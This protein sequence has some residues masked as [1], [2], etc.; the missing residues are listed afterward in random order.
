MA[1]PALLTRSRDASP[2]R[3]SLGGV[4]RTTSAAVAGSALLWLSGPAYALDLP[5]PAEQRAQ[6]LSLLK[7]VGARADRVLVSNVPGTVVNDEVVLVGLSEAGTPAR[8]LM[9]QRL[10]LTGIGDYNVRERG[11]ARASEALG[12]EPPPVTKFGAVV[13]QGFSPGSRELAARLTLDPVIEAARL[14]LQVTVSGRPLAPGGLVPAAGQV[15]LRLT[16]RTAQP[17]TLPTATDADA[18]AVARALDV[19]RAAAQAPAGPRLPAAGTGL[20]TGLPAAVPTTGDR[21]VTAPS[22]VSLRVTG[23]VRLVDGAGGTVTGPATTAVPGGAQV[24]GTLPPGASAD[25]VVQASGPGR[26][27]LDLTV[28]PALDPRALVP[29]DRAA[30]W[31]AWAATSPDRTARR[32]ALDLLVATASSGARATSLSPYLGADLPGSGT[33]RFTYAFA[34]LERAPVAAAPLQPRPVP[35]ALASV[36]LL[37]LGGG[38][39]RLWRRS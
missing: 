26:L 9:E 25:L 3:P 16:N 27:D 10:S 18:G 12:D 7:E 8:V 19:A 23:T 6:D 13:W 11:P 35:I 17:A 21:Q 39:V 36:A 5:S 33:T 15:V 32:A 30:S 20:S 29:P 31:V 22:G 34:A 4:R 37:A 1:R 14:P 28:V 24:A 38:A 2:P